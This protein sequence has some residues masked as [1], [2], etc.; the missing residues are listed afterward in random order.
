M[1]RR[2]R[3]VQGEKLFKLATWP[4]GLILKLLRLPFTIV[5][6]V[7]KLG[8]MIMVAIVVAGIVAAWVYFG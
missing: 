3:G 7:M 6:C 5:S 1:F 2:S 8:C 4:T